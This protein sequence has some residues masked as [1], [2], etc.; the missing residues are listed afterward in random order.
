M[1]VSYKYISTCLA[2]V[3]AVLAVATLPRFEGT[4]WPWAVLLGGYAALGIWAAVALER[5]GLMRGFAR[6][7]S[8]DLTLGIVSGLVVAG[9]ALFVLRYVA[10]MTHPRGAWLFH[11]YAQFGD[12]QGELARAV[13]LLLVVALEELVWRGLV[14]THCVEQWGPK[15]GLLV[16]AFTYAAAHAP[17]LFTL[18]DNQA[19][20]NPL[21]VMGALACGL[22]WGLMVLLTSRLAPAIVCHAVVSYFVC[23]PAPTWLW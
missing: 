5:D 17:T 8:G 2:A 12:V 21:L 7:R 23:A 4:W 6:P 3:A 9:A 1:M 19:G 16:S 20:P 11:L 14:Q 18:Q 22:V 13:A 15:R 10:P